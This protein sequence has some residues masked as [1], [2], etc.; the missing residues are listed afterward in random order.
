[1]KSLDIDDIKEILRI[2]ISKQILNAHR[3]R[4]GSQREGMDVDRFIKSF[5]FEV[6]NPMQSKDLDWERN[7]VIFIFFN[8]LFRVWLNHL[9]IVINLRR[10]LN[11]QDNR[12]FKKVDFLH[13]LK[14]LKTYLKEKS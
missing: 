11:Q 8:F 3:V 6:M 1:M 9:I 10:S 12:K 7:N 14:Y 5:F 13:L 2:E 4:E